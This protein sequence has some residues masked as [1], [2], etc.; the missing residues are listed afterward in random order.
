MSL[1]PYLAICAAGAILGLLALPFPRVARF[2]GVAALAAAFVAAL[3]IKPV[4]ELTV[5]Q[6]Q[7]ATSWYAGLF[8]STATACCLLLCVLGLAV[9][10][11]E[12]LAPAALATFGGLAVAFTATDPGVVFAA[13]AASAVPATLVAIGPAVQAH[14][15]DIS[16]SEL[17]TLGLIAAGALVASAVVVQPGWT[18][19]DPT[20]VFALAYIA[21]GLAV[22]VR[23]GAVPFHVPA[24]RLSTSRAKLGLALPLVWI[25]A[26]LGIVALSWDASVF[27]RHGEWLDA[28]VAG[29]QVVAVATLVL[30][31]LGALLH[32]ELEEI[33]TYSIIQDAAFVLLA[34]V[35]RDA[36]AAEP[37]R[38]WLLA[39]IVAKSAL[40]AWV[41]ALSYTF[42]SSRLQ[43]LRGW[44]RRSPILGLALLAIVVATLGWPG[45][46]VYEARATI[47][48][49]A[50]PSQLQFLGFVGV[51][52]AVAYYG[53]LI[54]VG[55]LG[56]GDSVMSSDGERPHRPRSQVATAAAVA[57]AG[58]APALTARSLR[59]RASRAAARDR[60]VAEASLTEPAVTETAP[61]VQGPGRVGGPE[62]AA[63]AAV[64]LASKAAARVRAGTSRSIRAGIAITR[65]LPAAR[66]LNRDIETS[67]LVLGI[68]ALSIA[69]AFGG[70]GATKAS[71]TGISLDAA[72]APT[73][74]LPSFGNDAPLGP[75]PTGSAGPAG[76]PSPSTV[77]ATP[78][79]GVAAPVGSA[80][81]G[82]NASSGTRASPSSSALPSQLTAD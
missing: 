42:G 40:V 65:R 67:L 55:L 71:S 10:W 73:P 4:D 80:S 15:L 51:L 45:N 60:S 43:D 5:G 59:S 69:I 68:S 12:R 72:V 17:R 30:G 64:G 19:S 75:A 34:L 6:V 77:S 11:P 21:L 35:A 61:A 58:S 47:V 57:T 3:A 39:F 22:A 52:G 76:A 36:D 7:L 14:A 50:L 48:R 25:P 18:T 1:V 74:Q 24:A 26:G 31:A 63:R 16:L 49:L 44:F 8:L 13:L 79:G 23:F 37:T 78:S 53:R 27:Q 62:R 2:V 66:R 28:A 33:A 54:A 20:F 38:L 46:A 70:F 82:P 32:N 9:G 29:L 56:P 41:T 81:S